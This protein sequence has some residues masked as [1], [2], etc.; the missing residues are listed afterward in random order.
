MLIRHILTFILLFSTCILIAQVASIE[1]P[2]KQLRVDLHID[3]NKLFYS[4]NFKGQTV[5]EKSPLGFISNEGDFING[6]SFESSTDSVIEKQYTQ[7]RI[8][9]STVSYYA[10]VLKTTFSNADK[11]SFSVTFQVSNNDI[12]F[13]YELPVWKETRSVVIQ[14]EHTGYKFPSTTTSFLSTMMKPMTGFAR[15]AVS[16]ESGYSIDAPIASA[17][18]DFGFV[19]PG[20]FKVQDNSWVLLSETG[21]TSAYCASHLS[22]ISPEGVFYVSYPQ[23]EQNNGFGSTGAALSLPGS[24]PWRTITIGD[25]LSPIVKTTI[26]FDV[27]EP[28]YAPSQNY[29]FGK[30]TWSWIV[31]QDQSMNWDDQIKYIDLA[32]A[33]KYPY[34]LIDALWDTN[35]GKDRMEKL[36]Q[37]ANSKNVDVFLWYNSNGAFNDAPQGPRNF[38]STSIARKKEMKWLQ[39]VG[40]KGLKVDFFGGDKQETMRLYEDILSDAN[41]YGLMIIFHGATLP[42]GWE[43]LYPNFVGS[44]AVLASE[45]LIF[46]QYARDNEAIFATLHPFIRNA[47][48]SME[49][50]G[51]FL[52]KFLTKDNS[53]RNKRLTT[54]GFQLATAVMFQNPIQPFALTPNNLTEAQPFLLDFMKRVPTTWDEVRLIDGY[55]GQYAIIARRHK[56]QWYLAGV[57]AKKES[58]QLK[59]DISMLKNKS[60]KIINDDMNKNP[61]IKDIKPDKNGLYEVTIQPNGGFVI[62]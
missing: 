57:N 23:Q 54:D 33:L 51:V 28:L 41:D 59:I 34:I 13:R 5:L 46:S 39:K 43:R 53:S 38:M 32:S 18:S 61:T 58:V 3:A 24:T 35:I 20:L 29:E 17:K 2:D 42:R 1:S 11:K 52:N 62:Y 22:E 45:M 50:G 30:S 7:D 26:P 6:I 10:N 27:V 8:K 25:N 16:Y 14:K 12:A 40:V 36:I 31:W 44:E 21:V 15:T 48:G 60:L 9:V 4:V 37:Y 56:E 47:V 19:F 49:F 55:P